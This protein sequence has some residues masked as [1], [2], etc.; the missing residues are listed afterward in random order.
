MSPNTNNS[1]KKLITYLASREKFDDIVTLYAFL[2]V[3]EGNVELSS[4]IERS[5]RY[6]L[7]EL[8]RRYQDEFK[9]Q[10]DKMAEV[11]E[12]VFNIPK[13]EAK[14]IIEKTVDTYS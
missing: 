8:I 3:T 13:E 1:R 12:E 14:K 6:L 10:I 9:N 11:V 5:V 2:K 4:V 7:K